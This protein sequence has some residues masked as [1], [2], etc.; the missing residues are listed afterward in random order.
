[1][2]GA[3]HD[4]ED[5]RDTPEV[6]GARNDHG[7]DSNTPDVGEAKHDHGDDLNTPDVGEAKNEL[8][9][10]S[11]K[12][13]GESE[14]GRAKDIATGGPWARATGGSIARDMELEENGRVLGEPVGLFEG[15]GNKGRGSGPVGGSLAK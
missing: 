13:R 7:D 12:P 14:E 1:M 8:G 2:G 5:G 10:D 3:K 4:L 6:G 11:D 15:E 9:D